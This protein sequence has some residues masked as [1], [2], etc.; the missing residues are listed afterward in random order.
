MRANN[1]AVA[2]L[3]D[4]SAA[5]AQQDSASAPA[6]Q[7]TAPEITGP[8]WDLV[9]FDVGCARCGHDLRSLT[10]P[11]CPQCKLEFDWAEAVPIESLVCDQCGYHLYGLS[12]TRC[13]ECGTII[14]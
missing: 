8:N 14:E 7:N 5:S 12:K 13:P 4:T 11:V 3:K 1:Q 10:E 2:P 9:P 6:S